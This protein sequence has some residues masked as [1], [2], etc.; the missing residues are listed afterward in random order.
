MSN[1]VL[2]VVRWVVQLLYHFTYCGVNGY[3]ERE[4]FIFTYHEFNI[5]DDKCDKEHKAISKY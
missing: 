2:T 1:G 5:Y 3:L 4:T